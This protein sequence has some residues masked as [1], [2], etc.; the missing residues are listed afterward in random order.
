MPAF[1]NLGLGGDEG[2]GGSWTKYKDK[3]VF[4]FGGIL[5]SKDWPQGMVCITT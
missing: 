4:C 5:E 2:R 1:I 3:N